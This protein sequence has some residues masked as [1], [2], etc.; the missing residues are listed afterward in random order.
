MA[1]VRNCRQCFTRFTAKRQDHYFCS[2][3]CVAAHYRD[4]P[5]PEYIHAEKEHI[6]KHFCEFCGSPYDINDYA[7]RGGKRT[8]K[9]CSGRCKQAAYRARGDAGK[10]QAERRYRAG[11]TKGTN[12]GKQQ[13]NSS[14]GRSSGNAGQ[15][16]GTSTYWKGYKSKWEAA[17]A[18]LNVQEG[19]TKADLKKA[20]KDLLRTKH[21]DV[22]KSPDATEVTK[23]INWAYEYLSEN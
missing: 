2:A 13:Q 14:K 16:N 7:E 18:I 12:T 20:W 6:H 19:F 21:P 5:N 17:R 22:N 3:R 10:Q 8:P 11:S 9:Y 15:S 23:Q 4:N 1:D